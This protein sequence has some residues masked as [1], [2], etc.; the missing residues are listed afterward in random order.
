MNKDKIF[1]EQ[2]APE[3]NTD[4]AFIQVGEDGKPEVPDTK[5][6]SE[7]KEDT[8]AENSSKQ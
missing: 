1:I 8:T 3:K 6:S 4:N 7:I 2:E 5:Q